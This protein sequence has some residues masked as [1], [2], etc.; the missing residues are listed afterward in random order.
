MIVEHLRKLH[1]YPFA[2]VTYSFDCKLILCYDKIYV[3]KN[4]FRESSDLSLNV[5]VIIIIFIRI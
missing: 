2:L 5:Y 3:I 4:I 1:R